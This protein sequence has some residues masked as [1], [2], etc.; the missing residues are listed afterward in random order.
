[1]PK[2]LQTIVALTLLIWT[3]ALILFG[4]DITPKKEAAL[5]TIINT[6]AMLGFLAYGAV[7]TWVLHR[8]T[9]PPA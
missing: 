4:L 1:M 9:P 7:H 6:A 5:E 3:N 2:F 8:G